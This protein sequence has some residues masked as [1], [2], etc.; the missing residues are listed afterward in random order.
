M[1]VNLSVTGLK[2]G[3]R[4]AEDIYNRR[5]DILLVAGSILNQEYINKISNLGLETVSISTDNEIET[6]AEK[7]IGLNR[8]DLDSNGVCPE[9]CQ[10]ALD[11]A[12]DIFSFVERKGA[13]SDEYAVQTRKIVEK[14]IK[15]ISENR[16]IVES[17]DETKPVNILV[18][19]LLNNKGIFSNLEEIKNYDQYTF[20]H[21]VDVCIMSLIIGLALKCTQKELIEL[22][23]GA[24][25][26]DI[27][28]IKV[29][30]EI[31]N[32][33]GKLTVEERQEI[34]KHPFYAFQI[35]SKNKQIS[36][37]AVNIAYQHHEKING[38]GYPQGLSGKYINKFAKIVAI[39]DVYD[40][41]ISNRCYRPAF[42]SYQ[43]A[44]IIYACTG[45]HFDPLIVKAFLDNII[46][47]P[48]ESLVE[49][50]DGRRGVVTKLNK[51]LPTRPEILLCYDK[52]GRILSPQ[53][54]IDLMKELT[55][56]INKV[57]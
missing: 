7:D 46:I 1:P 24:L 11:L 28:K 2:P 14:I 16:I 57:L 56:F 12:K 29:P 35:L 30:R 23:L 49:L 36:P 42:F 33:P 48:V 8:N 38:E 52:E 55:L 47:Y 50:N 27:G 39:I 10:E 45:T 53:I 32:K 18:N 4:L 13:L 34:E 19:Q 41:L 31:I 44:E 25:L 54:K 51:L 3:M 37:L 5:G 40:A 26:H 6:R 20:E 22:G 21:S 15:E 17:L 43:A 9:T